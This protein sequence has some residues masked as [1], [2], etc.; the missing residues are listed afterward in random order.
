VLFVPPLSRIVKNGL[1]A[2]APLSCAPF[3]PDLYFPD[4]Y[5]PDP[6]FMK[7]TQ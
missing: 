6:Y 2:Y 3:F 5:F 1:P 4:L 7:E